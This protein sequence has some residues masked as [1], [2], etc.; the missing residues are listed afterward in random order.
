MFFKKKLK[1]NY[2]LN[3]KERTNAPVEPKIKKVT[4]ND[5]NLMNRDLN[6]DDLIKRLL[7]G[8]LNLE[9]R[10]SLF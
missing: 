4:P 5:I 10:V 6:I 8:K 2:T 3:L 9:K 7:T 1:K